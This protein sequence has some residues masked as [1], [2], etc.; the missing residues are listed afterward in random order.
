MATD[1]EMDDLTVVVVEE[2]TAADDGTDAGEGGD[3]EGQ[4]EDVDVVVVGEGS[5]SSGGGKGRVGRKYGD[6]VKGPWSPEED[7]ILSRLVSNFG[8]RNWSLI[9]RGI[10]GRSGKSCRLRWCNQLDPAVKRKPFTD[11]EDRLIVQAHTIHGNKWA[12]IARLLPGRTDN[13]IKNHW[14]STLRRRCIGRGKLKLESSNA[15]EDISIDRSKA[16]SEETL[17][18]GDVNSFKSLEGKDVSSRESL[19]E[20][21]EDKAQPQG[22]SSDKAKEPPTLFRPVARVSA[23]N[24]FNPS[25]GPETVSAFPRPIPRQGPSVQASPDA[26][27]YKL[28]EGAYGERL[29]PQ[30]CGHGCC[31]TESV[32][33]PRRSLLG[34]EFVDYAEPPFFPSHEL[35]AIATDISNIAWQKSGL[36]S[37]SVRA[38]ENVNVRIGSGGPLVQ[39]D[40]FEENRKKGRLRFEEGKN[41]LM[42]MVTDVQSTSTGRQTS[43]VSAKVGGWT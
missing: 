15:V 6:R 36:E 34:P 32:G 1:T 12:S 41:K 43:S 7:A 16:S 42:G 13:A 26:G 25:N 40:H 22:Q 23:F 2:S 9:A 30:Q 19:E 38:V 27:I 17:S 5:G 20:Q 28:L 10:A 37:S 3:G 24:V 31:E 21:L 29:I 14:N 39:M 33:K 4:N 11:E 35:A 18:C 8:A